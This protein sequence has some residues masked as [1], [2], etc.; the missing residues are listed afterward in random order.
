[1][2]QEHSHHNLSVSGCHSMQ[3]QWKKGKLF[4]CGSINI[5]VLESLSSTK[6]CGKLFT[7]LRKLLSCPGMEV[8]SRKGGYPTLRLGGPD[9]VHRSVNEVVLS[10]VGL[11]SS[12]LLGLALVVEAFGCILFVVLGNQLIVALIYM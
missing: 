1:M 12:K 6:M 10:D 7:E 2:A 8:D 3:E 5:I 4:F 11:A 9:N